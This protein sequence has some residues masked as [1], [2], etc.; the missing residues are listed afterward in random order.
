MAGILR[1]TVTVLDGGGGLHSAIG[2]QVQ[3][4]VFPRILICF[5]LAGLLVPITLWSDLRF[6]EVAEDSGIAF[7]HVASKTAEKYLVEAMGAGVATLDFDGDGLLD[8]Y[9]VNGA[10]LPKLKRGTPDAKSDRRYWN[11]LY[12]N[13][14]DWRFVDVTEQAGVAGHGYGMGVAVADYDAD[15][16]PD[17]FVS[18]F[19]PDALFRNEGNGSFREVSDDAGIEGTDWST[20]AAFLDFNGDGWLDLFVSRYLEWSFDESKPCGEALP[21]RRS[22]CHPRVFSPA[23]HSLYRNLGDGRFE[24][25]ST[26][27]GIAAHPGKGLGVA[28]NDFDDDGWIDI[29]VANDSYPQQ[30]FHNMAGKRFEE[31]AVTTGSAYDAE[32]RE[33]A[34]MGVVWADYDRDLRP[35]LLVNALGRQGYWLYRNE[36]ARFEPVSDVSGLT[37]LSELRSGWGMGLVDFDNDGWRDLIVGQGHVMDDIGLSDEALAHNEPLMLARNLF[38]RFYDVSRQAGAVFQRPFPARGIAFGDLDGDGRV[39]AAVNVNDGPALVLR[40]VSNAGTGLTVRLVGTGRNRDA[41]GAIVQV[42]N[43]EG[44]EQRAFRGGGGSYLSATSPDI[45]FGLGE[46]GLCEWITV[47]WPDG[48]TQTVTA[49]DDPLVVVRQAAHPEGQP[50]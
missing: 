28:V 19:G 32:G 4:I 29:F 25:V 31:M 35:D 21:Q 47:R 8:V 18:N 22:Y 50:N 41:V 48:S 34:G 39:D 23:R 14:G 12:R 43:G 30:L 9:F 44:V 36:G 20:G 1:G 6:A 15:G 16:D 3:R 7:R 46:S 49:P 2:L 38:G 45:H 11:R 42:K 5:V 33:Y 27:T 40:N 17:L 24:D 10:D 13:T 26:A 37:A